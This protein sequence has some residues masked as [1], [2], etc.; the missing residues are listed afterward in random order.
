MIQL[1]KEENN[2]LLDS[3]LCDIIL[4]GCDGMNTDE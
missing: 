4:L 3:I 2:I 1:K